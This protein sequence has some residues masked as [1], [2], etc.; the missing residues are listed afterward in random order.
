[1][2]SLKSWLVGDDPRVSK[3]A[4]PLMTPQQQA[5]LDKLLGEF[6]QAD[7]L[8]GRSDSDI[9]KYTGDFVA[10]L[11]RLENLSLEAL[12]QKILQQATGGHGGGDA[13]QEMIKNKGSPV[14]FEDYYR[15][16]IENPTLKSF[17]EKVLPMLTQRFRGSAAFGSDRMTAERGATEDP[18]KTLTGARSELAYKTSSDASNRLLQAIGL[19]G[20]LRGSDAQAMLALLQG[21]GL[22]RQIEQADK[23]AKYGEFQRQETEKST[24][25]TK[26]L[27]A[28]MAALGLKTQQNSFLGL[29]GTEGFAK[30]AL[31]EVVKGA[32]SSS[33]GGF[34][35]G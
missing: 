19:E 15:D 8:T 10:P 1:M 33:K 21:A 34:F 18:T 23:T 2:V 29:P 7:T 35:G 3:D 12:E 27:E 17:E 32:S 9:T 11:G 5:M 14:N 28:L 26:R 24:Q 13:L 30:P 16:S 22:P 20:S 31:L 6:D 25:Q 4:L